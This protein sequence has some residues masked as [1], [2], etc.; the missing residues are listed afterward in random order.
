M[1]PTAAICFLVTLLCAV[2]LF[3]HESP[4]APTP[5]PELKKQ[6]FF[7][8]NWTLEGTTKSSPFGT[9]GQKFTSTERL[10]WMPGGFF[11]LAHSYA[12][13]RLAGVTVI[14][15]D[16]K[17]KIFTHT[18]FNTQGETE[19]WTGI[20]E[21]DKWIWT[22]DEQVDGKRVRDRLTINKASSNSYSFIVEM[23]PAGGGSWAVVAEGTGTR[24]E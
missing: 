8:G 21:S 9:G 2:S 19:F 22:R 1:K 6:D 7:V 5:S 13:K 16:S 18:R 17:E 12:G 3:A 11:L 4:S 20:A 10:E 23:Q 24:T 14:G 15:Y